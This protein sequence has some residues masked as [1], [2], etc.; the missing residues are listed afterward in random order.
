MEGWMD[1]Y[2]YN[3]KRTAVEGDTKQEN[4]Y[5]KPSEQGFVSSRVVKY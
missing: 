1:R 5:K 4:N 3:S 2:I